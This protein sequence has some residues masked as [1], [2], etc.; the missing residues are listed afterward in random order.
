MKKQLSKLENN[1]LVNIKQ[2]LNRI[3]I[4]VDSVLESG[5]WPRPYDPVDDLAHAYGVSTF[6]VKNCVMVNMKNNSVKNR[7]ERSDKGRTLFNSQD[8]RD[9][10]FIP[11]NNYMKT[12]RKQ[13]PGER[14]TN[15]QL[16]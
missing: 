11:L 4:I 14:F 16:R 15:T 2:E 10:H 7:R 9:R 13:H 1:K 12:K 6:K 5:H 8:M 3:W